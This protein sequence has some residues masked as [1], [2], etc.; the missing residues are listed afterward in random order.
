MPLNRATLHYIVSVLPGW[1]LSGVGILAN[2]ALGP[3]ASGPLASVHFDLFSVN[4]EM[5]SVQGAV[6]CGLSKHQKVSSTPVTK[7]LHSNEGT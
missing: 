7:V 6:Y 3:R 4:C 2:K 1:K 5:S